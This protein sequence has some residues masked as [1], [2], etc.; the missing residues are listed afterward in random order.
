MQRLKETP[1]LNLHADEPKIVHDLAQ[2]SFLFILVFE[3]PRFDDADHFFT[4]DA[5]H[6]LLLGSDDVCEETLFVF[7][8]RIINQAENLLYPIGA[9]I[10]LTNSCVP[11]SRS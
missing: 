2:H 3:V 10:V 11:E 9:K 6:H 1:H 8:K 4:S 7:L 5:V